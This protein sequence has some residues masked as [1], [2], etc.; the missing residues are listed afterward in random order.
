MSRVFLRHPDEYCH[1]V[2][3]MGRL[4]EIDV[5]VEIPRD[6]LRRVAVC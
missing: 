4:A 5:E 3:D 2:C 6:T 1:A